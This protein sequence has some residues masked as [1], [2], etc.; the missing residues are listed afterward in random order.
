M[1]RMLVAGGGP[2]GTPADW[3]NVPL[4]NTPTMATPGRRRAAGRGRCRS[5][6]V[7]RDQRAPQSRR[8]CRSRSDHSR[9]CDGA[10]RVAARDWSAPADVSTCGSG[11]ASTGLEG[12]SSPARRRLNSR[13][14][15]EAGRWR[16]HRPTTS[17]SLSAWSSGSRL[18]VSL[19]ATWRTTGASA[20]T[21]SARSRMRSFARS[22][23]SATWRLTELPPSRS[24]TTWSARIDRLVDR[25]ILLGSSTQRR[26]LPCR[27]RRT[28]AN[29]A[30]RAAQL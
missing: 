22:R 18:Q 21:P 16:R 20:S 9:P 13:R 30:R 8:P 10:G 1:L 23:R 5:V 27:R 2:A 7:G 4:P 26:F 11:A 29:E 3:P 15:R 6:R 14:R 24:R 28:T 12:P 25:R 17:P 19:P